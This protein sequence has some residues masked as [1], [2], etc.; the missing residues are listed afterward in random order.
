MTTE[1]RDIQ[2]NIFLSYHN[3]GTQK[4]DNSGPNGQP[5]YIGFA[6]PGTPTSIGKWQIRRISYDG[7]SFVTDVEFADGVNTFNKKWDDRA[8]YTYS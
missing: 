3:N 2:Q 7:N 4:M 1:I 6:E 5:L 8:T